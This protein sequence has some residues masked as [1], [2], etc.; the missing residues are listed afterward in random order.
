M[1]NPAAPGGIRMRAERV[2]VAAYQGASSGMSTMF[3]LAPPSMP[4]P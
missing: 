4:Y 3:G 2:G 1:S